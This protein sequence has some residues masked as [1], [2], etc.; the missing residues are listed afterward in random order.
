VD[1]ALPQTHRAGHQ[2]AVSHQKERCHYSLLHLVSSRVSPGRVVVESRSMAGF[3][4]C[5]E[6]G[7]NVVIVSYFIVFYN[8]IFVYHHDTSLQRHCTETMGRNTCDSVD[9]CVES[10]AEQIT[11]VE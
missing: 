5:I 2:R 8:L 1:A 7:S 9:W 10:C 4:R 3:V 11:S 6:E